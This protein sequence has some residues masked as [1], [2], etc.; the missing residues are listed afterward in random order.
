MGH[1]FH[2]AEMAETSRFLGENLSRENVSIGT[3]RCESCGYPNRV[4]VLPWSPQVAKVRC[5]QQNCGHVFT[6]HSESRTAGDALEE[7][8]EE[9]YARAE[10]K[11][12]PKGFSTSTSKTSYEKTG[13]T[14][15]VRS[16][17]RGSAGA[18]LTP[19]KHKVVNTPLGKAALIG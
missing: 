18:C 14:E 15:V 19:F 3:V 11:S 16:P 6:V 12:S 9:Q 13:T 5:A 4:A 17:S 2:N 8:V 10:Q 7:L 1:Q